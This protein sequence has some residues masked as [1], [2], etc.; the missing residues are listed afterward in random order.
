MRDTEEMLARFRRHP[1]AFAASDTPEAFAALVSGGDSAIV[2]MYTQGGDTWARYLFRTAKAHGLETCPHKPL[3]VPE[4]R[5]LSELIE[6][7]RYLPLPEGGITREQYKERVGGR[8]F[9]S[10]L[11]SGGNVPF[12]RVGGARDWS[13][14]HLKNGQRVRRHSGSKS[15][16]T[17][18][19]PTP[20]LRDAFA[21]V[22]G[23][24][25][26]G[27]ELIRW[28]CGRVLVIVND[29]DSGIFRMWAALLDGDKA[30]A[31]ALMPQD[32]RDI[33]AREKAADAAAWEDSPS[34]RPK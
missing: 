6:D 33:I 5:A 16:G 24:K 20:L 32:D 9:I 17:Y 25:I 34:P 7:V 21:K 1:E 4:A 12:G 15:H 23:G 26:G 10:G 31:A 29:S 28:S 18:A 14:D 3:Y 8:T 2:T 13:P 30:D 22:I 19:R 11:R 27:I